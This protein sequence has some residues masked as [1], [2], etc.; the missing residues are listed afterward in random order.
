MDYITGTLA[1]IAFLV[2]L[3]LQLPT[4]S[5]AATPATETTKVVFVCEHGSVKSLIAASYFNRSAQ[6]RGLPYRAVARGTAPEP[7]VPRSVQKGLRAIEVDASSYVPKLFQASDVEGA[8]LVVSFDQDIA[9]I[10]G[11]RVRHLKWDNLPAVLAD[12]AR[13]RDSIVEHVDAL[14]EALGQGHTP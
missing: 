2:V 3:G 13:G 8:S 4:A 7:H 9:R 5:I 12:Y 11:K 6:A 10:V 1:R 14:I